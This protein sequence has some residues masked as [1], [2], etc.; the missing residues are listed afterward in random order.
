MTLESLGWQMT[1]D[2]VEA[3]VYPAP[4]QMFKRDASPSFRRTSGHC[5]QLLPLI[6]GRMP[7]AS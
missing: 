1:L 4:R 2:L 7:H 5:L 3:E 6:R